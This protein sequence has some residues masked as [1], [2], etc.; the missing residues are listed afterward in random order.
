MERGSGEGQLSRAGGSSQ[1]V[2]TPH[3]QPGTQAGRSCLLTF[4]Q[5][6]VPV[7]AERLTVDSASGQCDGLGIYL[8]SVIA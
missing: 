2:Q 3:V 5:H 7:T 1:P 4:V 6:E 8:S